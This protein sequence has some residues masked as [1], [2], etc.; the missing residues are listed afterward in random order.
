MQE[1]P[2][3]GPPSQRTPPASVGS[4]SKKPTKRL[5]DSVLM[6]RTPDEETEDGR[7]RNREAVSKIRDAWIYKQVR[8]R[9][10][11]FTQYQKVS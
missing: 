6:T 10:N 1:R 9:Q 5:E 2:V 3:P 11:E 4:A 8:A 7:I